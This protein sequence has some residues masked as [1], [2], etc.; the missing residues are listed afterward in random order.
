MGCLGKIEN[1]QEVR[2]ITVKNIKLSDTEY[3]LRFKTWMTPYPNH[4]HTIRFQDIVMNNVKNSIF[5]HQELGLGTN[6]ALAKSSHVKIS[7]VQFVNITGTTTSEMGCDIQ[8]Q[9]GVALRN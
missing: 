1:E 2:N 5:L 9:R 6:Y 4:A 8:V 3:V 7:D